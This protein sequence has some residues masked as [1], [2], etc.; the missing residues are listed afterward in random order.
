MEVQKLT[1]TTV[2]HT[3]VKQVFDAVRFSK[4]PEKFCELIFTGPAYRNLDI[5]A[6][7]VIAQY[8]HTEEL[9]LISE[10][11]RKGEK[12]DMCLALKMIMQQE[13]D[14]G[15]NEG[16]NEGWNEGRIN[17]ILDILCEYGVVSD[18]LRSRITA[19]ENLET[20]KRWVKLAALVDSIE[21]FEQ[22][23]G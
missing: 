7:D 8:V 20:L 15:W 17:S 3:D 16:R 11:K 10:M 14:E 9:N 22:Q 19:E 13:R 1:D 21:E 6:Y 18:E 23:I 4:D 5:E 2:F 12:V